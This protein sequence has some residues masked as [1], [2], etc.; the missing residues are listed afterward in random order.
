MPDEVATAAL[1]IA[2]G[3]G[4][5]TYGSIIGAGGGFLLVPA[6]LLLEPAESARTIT[7]ISLAAICFNGISA[8]LAYARLGRID[9]PSGI[10]LATSAVPGAIVGAWATR[11]VPRGPFDLAFGVLLIAIAGYL[12]LPTPASGCARPTWVGLGRAALYRCERHDVL[13]RL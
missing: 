4:V 11:F 2:L 13:L 6:L 5:A 9:V 8:T 3:L 7:T 1:L 12:V 10:L